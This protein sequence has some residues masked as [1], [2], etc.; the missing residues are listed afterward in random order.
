MWSKLA[1]RKKAREARQSKTLTDDS[2]IQVDS[3]TTDKHQ[4][5]A[6]G[7]KA[8]ATPGTADSVHSNQPGKT[9]WPPLPE[10]VAQVNASADGMAK[11]KEDV[12]SS[13]TV[14]RGRRGSDPGDDTIP[15]SWIS[16]SQ[17]RA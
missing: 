7:S 11:G 12:V 10:N 5:S 8:A 4:T 13:R 14:K 6:K 3:S 17:L 1:Q 9:Y 2:A 16:I 15:V